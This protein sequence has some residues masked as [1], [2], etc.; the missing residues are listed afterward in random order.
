VA[1]KIVGVTL[2]A[3]V[4]DFMS[5]MALAA[6][7]LGGFAQGAAVAGQGARGFMEGVAASVG[8]TGRLAAKLAGPA[9]LVYLLGKSISAAVEFEEQFVMVRKTMDGTD[10]QLDRVA[11][12]I[13]KVATELPITTREL[14]NI[15]TVAG[16]LGIAVED[17]DHFVETMAMVSMATT[18]T[19]EGAAIDFARLSNILGE[20]IDQVDELANLAVRLG[21]NMAAQEPEIM[22]FAKRI[23]ASGTQIG[24]TKEEIMALSAALPALG[25]RAEMG[26]T[27]ISRIMVE[28]QDAV[29]TGSERLETFARTAGMSANEF[30]AAWGRTGRNVGCADG[31]PGE[32][33]RR[34]VRRVPGARRG[35]AGDDPYPGHG[36]ASVER[37]SRSC[38]KRWRSSPTR[39]ARTRRC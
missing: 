14:N 32:R 17:M 19:A 6:R 30:A 22:E 4:S 7:S 13:R 28:I 10:E 35:R 23:A 21:N 29:S 15:A 34:R 24:M 20:P 38:R 16:Q 37:T 12:S 18:L 2:Q 8:P 39:P 33:H 9:G 5:K 36:V 27:A 11:L 26:G 25:L 31:R 3:N 1:N